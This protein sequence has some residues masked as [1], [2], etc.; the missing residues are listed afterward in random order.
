MDDEHAQDQFDR[1]KEHQ[2]I[3]K[4]RSFIEQYESGLAYARQKIEAAQY[5]IG[6][7]DERLGD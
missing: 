6:R 1:M 5:Q 7:L 2:V 3:A 4:N